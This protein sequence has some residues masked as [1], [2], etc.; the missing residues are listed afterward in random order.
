MACSG[1]DTQVAPLC[2]VRSGGM[3]RRC[4]VVSEG[5]LLYCGTNHKWYA[6]GTAVH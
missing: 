6:G 5:M 3:L 2:S 1:D 4:N